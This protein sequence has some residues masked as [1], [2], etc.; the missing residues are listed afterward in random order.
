MP[1]NGSARTVRV[2]TT[3]TET[4]AAPTR[5]AAFPSAPS[6]AQ[7]ATRRVRGAAGRRQRRAIVLALERPHRGFESP[8]VERAPRM[9]REPLQQDVAT[10]QQPIRVPAR[11]GRAPR[12][13][14][15]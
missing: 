5:Q 3:L 4:T 13:E 15:M 6:G 11:A 1:W 7:H 9:P 2:A 8:G 14:S 12:V 10:L